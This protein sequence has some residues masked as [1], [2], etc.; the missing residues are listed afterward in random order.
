[1]RVPL[2]PEGI[3]GIVRL[4]LPTAVHS[5]AGM[6]RSIILNALVVSL[7]GSIGMTVL[8][9]HGSIMDFVDI[10]PVGISGAIGILAG[11]TYGELVYNDALS[12]IRYD[13]PV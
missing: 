2:R 10:L 7:G 1:M 12:G 4:G 6:L 3:G 13:P 11:I 8:A 9:L 5:A